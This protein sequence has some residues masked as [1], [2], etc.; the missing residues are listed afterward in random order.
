MRRKTI[1]KRM[2]AKLREI[3]SQLRRRLHGAIGNAAKWLRQLRRRSQRSRWTW[4]RFMEG[5]GALLPVVE[6]LHP[7]PAVRFYATHPR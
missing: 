6:I 7:H 2:A 5:L 4:K 3:R 1:G